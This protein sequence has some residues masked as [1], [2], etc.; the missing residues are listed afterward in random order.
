MH[1]LLILGAGLVS[2]PIVRYF[3]EREGYHSTVASLYPADA[4]ALVAGHPRG[5]AIGVDVLDDDQLEPLLLDAELVVSLVPYSMH[6]RVARFAVQ[7]GVHMITASYVQPEI[8]ALDAEARRAGVTVLNELGLDPG[9]DHLSA[10]H[11]IDRIRSRGGRVESFSS[12]TGGLPA[13]EAAD[14][15]WR[16]KFSWSP[17]GA[18]LAGRNAATYLEDGSEVRISG[19]R[20]FEHGRPYEVEGLGSMEMYPNRDSTRYVALYGI[21]GVRT[22]L[23]GTLRYPGWCETMLALSRLGMLEV[24]RRSW[25]AGT[26]WCEFLAGFLPSE[27]PS[28][29]GSL[30]ERL[31]ARLEL[32]ADHAVIER[33]EWAGL[34]SD[35]QLPELDASPLDLLADLFQVRMRY[36]KR[37]R[38]MVV[39]RHEIVARYD[40][41]AERCVARLVAYGEPDGD[42]A[43]SR[44]VSYPAAIAARLVLEGKLSAPGVHVPTRADIYRPILAELEGLGIAFEER[45]EREP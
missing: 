24:E 17:R 4:E 32:P 39:M 45:F 16:Y 23:R 20:L 9:L 8:Q 6:A 3:L 36:R 42:S 7:H 26:R 22:M 12:C 37:E 10:M 1:R 15:P 27:P 25:P 5:R 43:T 31:A 40:D 11:L 34:L 2:R 21:E 14:N 44:T 18:L 38:D 35:E 41:H 28:G 29:A 30:R 13:P 33:F 19:E